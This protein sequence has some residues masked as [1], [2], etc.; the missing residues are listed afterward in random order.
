M[1]IKLYFLVCVL[2]A[3]CPVPCAQCPVTSDLRF[4]PAVHFVM[5]RGEINYFILIFL[6]KSIQS[7]IPETKNQHNLTHCL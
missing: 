2:H 7:F 1:I 4:I 3:L 6:E 5:A